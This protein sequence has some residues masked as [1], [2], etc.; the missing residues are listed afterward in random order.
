MTFCSFFPLLP[1]RSLCVYTVESTLLKLISS[2]YIINCD[3]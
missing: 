1:Y 2:F 3:S